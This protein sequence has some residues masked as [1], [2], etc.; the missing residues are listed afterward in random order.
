MSTPSYPTNWYW[1]VGNHNPTTQVW[2]GLLGQYDANNSATYQAW[3]GDPGAPGAFVV[4]RPISGAANNGAGLIR[5]ALDTTVGYTTGDVRVVQNVGGTT[6]ANGTWPLTV[7]D[8][9]HVDLQGSVFVHAYTSGGVLGGGTVIDTQANLFALINSYN[10][11]ALTT[12]NF[13]GNQS[14]DLSIA[15]V[16]LTNPITSQIT[17][18]DGGHNLL[19]PQANLFGSMPIGAPFQVNLAYAAGTGALVSLKNT[20]GGSIVAN[21]D[22]GQAFRITLTKNDTKEG[23]WLATPVMTLDATAGTLAVGQASGGYATK[24]VSGD[25]SLNANGVAALS[26]VYAPM[27]TFLTAHRGYIA[28]LTL[29]NDGGSP[30]TV[31]DVA[32]GVCMSDDVTV[33]MVLSTF[34]KNANAVWAV[35]TGSGSA[36]GA[37]SY[38]TLGASTWYHVYV[39]ERID[40]GAVDVLTSKS[41]TTPTLPT[42]YTVKRRIGSFRTDGSSHIMKFKQDGDVFQWDA[43]VVDVNASNGTNPGTA[44]VTRVLTTPL[45]VRCQ[46]LLQ[47]GFSAT[48]PATDNPA[49]VLISDLSV[50]NQAPSVGNA[51]ILC[52][53]QVNNFFAPAKVFTDTSSQVRSRLQ[54]ST[55]GTVL[56]INTTG[57]E[58]TR[59]RFA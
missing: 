56:S 13:Y 52:Y 51:T 42:S 2:N 33:L 41:A 47:V 15:D 26:T 53:S 3:V 25:I 30:N 57:W 39:I 37:A 55:A 18:T 14:I 34:T 24:G 8:A 49:G 6:E 50:S 27:T 31:I 10:L 59:G 44:A 21:A 20:S 35:G 11:T 5:L 38:T 46:A 12:Q 54:I 7:V 22:G 29:S 48:T 36:D 9:T 16:A 17:I 23:S 28:G 4:L 40:T 32:A 43:T 19:F 1:I 58:D 45:G